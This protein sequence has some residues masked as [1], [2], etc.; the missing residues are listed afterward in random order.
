M[1][2]RSIPSGSPASPRSASSR[3][4]ASG[5]RIGHAGLARHRPA[6]RGDAGL[7]ARL[8]EPRR[9]ELVM[10]R[11]RAEVPEHRIA[12]AREQHAARALVAR[13]FPDVRARDVADVVLVEEQ[14]RAER[15][16]RAAT[17][18]PSPAARSGASRSRSAAPS[19]PPSSRR[20][21]RCSWRAPPS[22]SVSSRRSV[23][24][25]LAWRLFINEKHNARGDQA[26]LFHVKHGE[27]ASY[28]GDGRQPTRGPA[29]LVTMRSSG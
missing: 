23:G 15:R 5:E 10:L 6:H 25:T 26:R 3:V 2:V 9:V 24:V 4:D 7:P 17:H 11:R 20:A 18:A 12:L 28:K 14:H 21:R 16:S 8:G 22:S 1:S 13:P 29:P 19:R 27:S